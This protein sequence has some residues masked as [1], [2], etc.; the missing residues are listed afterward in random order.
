MVGFNGGPWGNP[1]GAFNRYWKTVEGGRYLARYK[2]GQ[3]NESI[4]GTGPLQRTEIE[5][6]ISIDTYDVDRQNALFLTLSPGAAAYRQ[7]RRHVLEF[8]LQEWKRID[9]KYPGTIT[10]FTTDSEVCDFSFRQA[11][12]GNALPIVYEEEMT[13]PFCNQEGISDCQAFFRQSFDYKTPQQVRW[14]EF[15]ASAHKQYVSDTV[16]TI[17]KYFPAIPIY[18]HQLGMLDGRYLQD[19]RAADYASPQETAFVEG[20]F[21]GITTGIYGKRDKD[22]KTLISEFSAKS[23]AGNW[24]LPEFNPGKDWTGSRAEL[25]EYSYQMFRFLSEHHVNMIA[26]LSWESNALDTGIKDSGVDDAV[27]RF[28]STGP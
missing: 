8:A 24:G 4:K 14:F 21:P 5:P 7:S 1:G 20:A 22:F 2:D 9:E 25:A 19:Y 10:A 17:R 28:I 23:V 6:F 3:V 13:R 26:L 11:P 27:K 18:T 12:S 16:Q 15:R